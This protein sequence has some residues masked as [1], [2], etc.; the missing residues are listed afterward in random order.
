MTAGASIQSTESF[1]LQP[2]IPQNNFY[3]FSLHCHC[4]CKASRVHR[5]GP[6]TPTMSP[7]G[8]GVAAGVAACAAGGGALGAASVGAQASN[9]ASPQGAFDGSHHPYH[10]CCLTEEGKGKRNIFGWPVC[11]LHSPAKPNFQNDKFHISS[12]PLRW[13]LN[14]FQTWRI[15]AV[16]RPHQSTTCSGLTNCPGF[17]VFYTGRNSSLREGSRGS[18]TRPPKKHSTRPS[19]CPTE[20]MPPCVCAGWKRLCPVRNG[21]AWIFHQPSTMRANDWISH[22]EKP[23]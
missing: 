17:L 22:G 5:A 9:G 23:R 7:I 2:N 21:F 4:V 13:E 14:D 11:L 1:L 10:L 6:N 18:G 3:C 15:L 16:D 19:M 8:W 12:F 20:R